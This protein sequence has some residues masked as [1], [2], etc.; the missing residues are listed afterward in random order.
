M[1]QSRSP[2]RARLC[3]LGDELLVE[4]TRQRL[5]EL[6]ID[7]HLGES[8]FTDENAGRLL[9]V[10]RSAR[11][12]A[13]IAFVF[14]RPRRPIALAEGL[15]RD[16]PATLMAVGLNLPALVRQPGMLADSERF[17]Q[18]LGSLVRLA[19]SAAVQKRQFLRHH[20]PEL[21]SNFLLDRARFVVTPIGLDEV[22]HL[23]T[24]WGLSNGGPSLELGRQIVQRLRDVLRQDGRAAQMAECLDGPATFGLDG[25]PQRRD[26]VAGL[27]PWA[28]P[29]AVR[30]QLRSAGALHA[31]SEHGTL[32]LFVPPDESV[33]A[34]EL[35]DSLRHA[36]RQ[37]DVVRL[38]MLTG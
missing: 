29:A 5:P 33:S 21:T 34:E 8:S 7:W 20:S 27:T 31:L 26:A 38:R 16:H 22:V 14:D 19:L 10:V 6:R 17:R 30:S 35:V 32:A 3:E 11:E 1:F 36:W 28:T 9:R 18:R 2:D 4:L 15:N 13:N 37:T 25:P 12:G 24:E 23:Y